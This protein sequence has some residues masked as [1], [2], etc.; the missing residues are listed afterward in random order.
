[1]QQSCLYLLG[2]YNFEEA[3]Q[4]INMALFEYQD[5]EQTAPK[6]HYA[7]MAYICNNY[8]M[9]L[10]RGFGKTKE[11]ILQLKN[12]LGMY[13][14]LEND[15]PD[16]Y[17][18]EA[19]MVCNNIANILQTYTDDI[20]KE[21]EGYYQEAITIIDDKYKHSSK[22]K[23]DK[24]LAMMLAD[25]SY[26]YWVY[27]LRDTKYENNRRMYRRRSLS[28]WQKRDANDSNISYFIDNSVRDEIEGRINRKYALV[29]YVQGGARKKRIW[30]NEFNI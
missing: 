16:S 14:K 12:S 2:G 30:S 1:M 6:T 18:Q 8:G 13:R 9:L 19:A 24:N 29:Y 21:V 5:L 26:N 28:Y 11:A 25:I 3:E 15:Y 23:G 27:M 10:L 17:F 22:L 20:S 7:N 4:L